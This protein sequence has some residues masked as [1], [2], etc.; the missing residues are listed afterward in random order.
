MHHRN[1]Y[2]CRGVPNVGAPA[3]AI[4]R[5][6]TSADAKKVAEAQVGVPQL[7]KDPSRIHFAQ[8]QKGLC[9][10]EADCLICAGARTRAVGIVCRCSFPHGTTGVP[11]LLRGGQ[12][13]E[14]ASPD[15]TTLPQPVSD[16]ATG[17]HDGRRH[18]MHE[19]GPRG[20][21]HLHQF[22]QVH[23]FVPFAAAL[24][25]AAQHT[26]CNNLHC[27]AL[28]VFARRQS[29]PRFTQTH[30]THYHHTATST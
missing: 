22:G 11:R 26:A 3:P 14:S 24:V 10:G 1:V 18:Y 5:G 20:V 21:L 8:A 30:L 7:G 6:N 13:G 23:R 28:G 25:P 27:C 4:A 12:R 16:N 15:H 9:D 2:E 19:P 17:S 29:A